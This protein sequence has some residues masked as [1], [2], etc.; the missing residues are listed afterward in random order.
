VHVWC[1][2][3]AFMVHVWCISRIWGLSRD[4]LYGANCLFA[5]K[6]LNGHNIIII[7]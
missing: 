4:F 7:I 1:F 3:G 6:S 2:Y 5:V